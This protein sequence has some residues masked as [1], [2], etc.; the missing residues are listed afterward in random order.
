MSRL[1][2]V[3]AIVL[4]STASL[5]STARLLAQDT[6]IRLRE[7]EER[8]KS[9]E[10]KLERVLRELGD[11]G[12]AIDT[13]PTYAGRR[14]TKWVEDIRDRDSDVREKA[15]RALEVFGADAV[16]P[17]LLALKSEDGFFRRNALILLE[18]HWSVSGVREGVLGC[19]RDSE[20]IVRRAAVH[21]LGRQLASAT[22]PQIIEDS[23]LEALKDPDKESQARASIYLAAKGSDAA[24]SQVPVSLIVERL[25]PNESAGPNLQNIYPDEFVFGAVERFGP[26]AKDAVP[27][28][29]SHLDRLTGN[30]NIDQWLAKS[31]AKCLA[32]IGPAALDAGVKSEDLLLKLADLAASTSIRGAKS[33]GQKKAQIDPPANVF[34]D[35]ITKLKAAE[36]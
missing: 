11:K 5:G 27:I 21:V 4:C 12:Q 23:L 19:A 29:Y 26:R 9:V 17:L 31:S 25:K 35:A 34:A 30:E 3:S 1:R 24:A 28:L 33:V 13:E 7:L 15:E 20:A 10:E 32:A 16:K 36:K 14:L 2:L 8:L 6:D 22:A 18:A